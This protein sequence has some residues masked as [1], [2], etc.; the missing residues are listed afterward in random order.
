MIRIQLNSPLQRLQFEHAGGPIEFGRGRQRTARRCVVSDP[1]VSGDQLAVEELSEN[2]VRLANLSGRTAVRIRDGADLAAGETRELGL[3]VTLAIGKTSIEILPGASGSPFDGVGDTVEVR[4]IASSTDAGPLQLGELG[5]RPTPEKLT[6]WF[7]TLVSLQTAATGSPEF[8]AEAARAL[9]DMI[10]LEESEVFLRRESAWE[11]AARYPAAKRGVSESGSAPPRALAEM[12]AKNDTVCRN[13]APTAGRTAAALEAVVAAPVRDREQRTIGCLFGRRCRPG[14][15]GPPNISPLD[16]QIVQLV[17]STIGVGLARQEK[18]AEAV[19]AR[20]QF[21]QFFSPVLARELARNP[22]LLTGRERAVS[23]LFADL[24][25]FSKLSERLKPLDVCAVV[26]DVMDAL[27]LIVVDHGGVVVDYQGDGLMAMW[28]APENQDDHAARACR[29]GLRMLEAMPAIGAPWRERVGGD[30]RLGVGVNSG[31]A[32]VGNIGSRRK[33]KYGPMGSCVNVAS[34][35]EGAT[36]YLGVPFVV[37]AGTRA[38]LPKSFA[39]RRLCRAR[40]AGMNEPVDLFE[41]RSD[42]PQPEF[43]ARAVTYER[44]LAE[45]ES[46]RFQEAFDVLHPLLAG[47]GAAKD[48]PSLRLAER[49]M[50]GIDAPPERF[51]GVFAFDKK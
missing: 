45:Y 7:E 1:Y 19:R 51:D 24:R 21:E 13:P 32:L 35:V 5:D 12:E 43:A 46:A 23:I 33:F 2:R 50:H 22:N 41:M 27:T 25:G 39:V 4:T 14:P 40:L 42:M 10:G 47:D 3:P 49:A 11:S 26:S 20:I 28:N 44:G 30:I 29:A 17:A 8:F 38:L 16:A 9:V 18:E 34:R 6:R 36:K 15:N 37:T 48:L 31:T